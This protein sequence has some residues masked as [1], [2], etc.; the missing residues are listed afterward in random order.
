M[1]RP[2]C[3]SL[4]F[5][6]LTCVQRAT[7]REIRKA[8]VTC[9]YLHALAPI[10]RVK[11]GGYFHVP[12]DKLQGRLRLSCSLNRRKRPTF[13]IFTVIYE[14]V[15]CANGG[16][17]RLPCARPTHC[18]GRAGRLRHRICTGQ[19]RRSSRPGFSPLCP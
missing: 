12:A 13:V 7:P 16:C 18:F 9:P 4:L 14:V 1:S 2:S 10:A 5:I 11:N 19:C 3:N 8:P 6:G 17:G 15:S